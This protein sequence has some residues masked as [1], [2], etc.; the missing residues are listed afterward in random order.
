MKSSILIHRVAKKSTLI[1]GAFY[2]IDTQCQTGYTLIKAKV[3]ACVLAGVF[4]NC[5]QCGVL[6]AVH[7]VRDSAPQKLN[8][9]QNEK[10]MGEEGGKKADRPCMFSGSS[11]SWV[12]LEQSQ[13]DT[14]KK[15]QLYIHT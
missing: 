4:L 13:K 5:V 15:R 9:G 2:Q 1:C 10:M 6:F 8:Q 3:R 11:C 14:P 12:S 7:K